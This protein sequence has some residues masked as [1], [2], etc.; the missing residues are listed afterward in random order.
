MTDML[1]DDVAMEDWM[2]MSDAERDAILEREMRA[3]N[4]WYDRLTP[5][6]RYRRSRGINVRLCRDWRR[7]LKTLEIEVFREHLR[8]AQIRLLKLRIQ[9]ATGIYPGQA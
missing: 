2:Q 1:D 4:E 5:L 3:Y 7:H 9:R 6:Q 8:S